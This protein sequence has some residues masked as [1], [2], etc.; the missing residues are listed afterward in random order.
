VQD[1]LVR[2]T[3][4]ADRGVRQNLFYVIR[5]SRIP[6]ILVEIGFV[7]HT[8]EGRR[9]TQ[10]DYQRTIASALADGIMEYLEN[11]GMIAERR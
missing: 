11:G 4:A 5:N 9:L 8:E 10:R 1:R 6:A 3:G 7:S 2:S